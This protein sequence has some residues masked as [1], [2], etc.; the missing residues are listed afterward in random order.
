LPGYWRGFEYFID[1]LRTG[2]SVQEQAVPGGYWKSAAGVGIYSQAC[3]K[4]RLELM[5]CCSI[6]RM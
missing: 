2:E 3:W 4:R 6:S 1:A 5:A